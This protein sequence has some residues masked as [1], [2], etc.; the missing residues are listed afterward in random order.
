M[1][2]RHIES[3]QRHRSDAGEAQVTLAVHPGFS[4]GL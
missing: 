1:L 4:F 3:R 2:E